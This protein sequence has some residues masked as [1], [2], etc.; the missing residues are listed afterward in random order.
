MSKKS[1]SDILL[2]RAINH[3]QRSAVRDYS[4]VALGV[5]RV[6][7]ESMVDLLVEQYHWPRIQAEAFK[8]QVFREYTRRVLGETTR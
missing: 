7:G 4:A 2:E 3:P 5:L 1:T 6:T 8:G